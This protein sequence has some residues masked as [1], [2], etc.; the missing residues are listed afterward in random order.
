VEWPGD[1]KKSE[2]K[3]IMRAL[4]LSPQLRVLRVG[5]K[6]MKDEGVAL[7]AA[8]MKGASCLASLSFEQVAFEDTGFDSQLDSTLES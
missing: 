7:L 2:A 1:Q 3:A 5:G 6:K 8:W 4:A